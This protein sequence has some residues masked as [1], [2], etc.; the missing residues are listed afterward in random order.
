MHAD[1]DDV[2]MGYIGSLPPEVEDTA[3]E[4]IL[5]AVMSSGRSHRRETSAACRRIVSETYSPPR[6]TA[7]FRRQRRPHLAPG[8]AFDPTTDDPD[9]DTPWDFSKQ[10]KREKA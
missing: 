8:F 4:L 6:V 10:E 3:S 9:D 2:N 1:S 5:Q 7:E